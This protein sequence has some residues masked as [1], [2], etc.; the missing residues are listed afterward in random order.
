MTCDPTYVSRLINIIIKSQYSF[1]SDFRL[2]IYHQ[3][4]LEAMNSKAAKYHLSK[5]GAENFSAGNHWAPI[6]K[7]LANAWEKERNP[8]GM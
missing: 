2:S 3:V 5:R 6:E 7:A 8:N 1:V 4:V